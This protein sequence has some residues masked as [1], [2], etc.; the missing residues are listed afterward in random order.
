MVEIETQGIDNEPIEIG[1]N[2]II[3]A[4]EKGTIEIE[5]IEIVI[6]RGIIETEIEIGLTESI[7][8]AIENKEKETVIIDR[9]S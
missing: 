9:I 2:E 6:G 7:E 3:I 4:R 8:I 1:E 5:V